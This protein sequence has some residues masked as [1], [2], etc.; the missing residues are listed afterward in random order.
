MGGQDFHGGDSPEIPPP[1]TVRG[2]RKAGIVIPQIL[3]HEKPRPVREHDIVL[4]EAFL[5][6]GRRRH[7][8]DGARP[9]AEEKHPAVLL[10]DVIERLVEGLFSQQVEVADDRKRRKR[11]RGKIPEPL[12]EIMA[13]NMNRNEDYRKTEVSKVVH[14]CAGGDDN[15]TLNVAVFDN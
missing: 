1:F 10:G 13:D 9:E 5:R 7:E 11:G 4:G 14:G 2:G 8:E 6:R 12:K 15:V 3:P